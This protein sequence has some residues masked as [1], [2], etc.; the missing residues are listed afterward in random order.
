MLTGDQNI[1]SVEAVY[2]IFV[3]DVSSFFYEVDDPFGT[4]RCAFET[5]LRRNLQNRTLDDALLNK[6]DIASKV[7]DDFRAMLA[8]YNLGIEVKEVM[9]QNISV[10]AEVDAAYQDVNNA[11]NEKTR[12]LDESE[13]YKNQ[14][15]PNARAHAY[16]LIQDAEAYKAET[17][18]NA[19]GEVATATYGSRFTAAVQS[20]KIFGVQFHPEKSST[21]GLQVLRNFV[22]KIR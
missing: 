15:V 12:K 6:Q 8:P 17:V 19:E 9:I 18:A 14:V 2:Q 22:E 10:P 20:G 4:M 1:V 3:K 11:K 5:V 7:R 16:K 21:A 13:K